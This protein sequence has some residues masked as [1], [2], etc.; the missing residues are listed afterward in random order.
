MWQVPPAWHLW[1]DSYQEPLELSQT[2]TQNAP[3]NVT[4]ALPNELSRPLPVMWPPLL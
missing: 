2:K 4:E 1:G 3:I